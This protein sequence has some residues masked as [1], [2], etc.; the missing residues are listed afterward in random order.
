MCTD[1]FCKV[2]IEAWMRPSLESLLSSV[3]KV[4]NVTVLLTAWPACTLA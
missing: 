1:R 4:I 2:E 3:G